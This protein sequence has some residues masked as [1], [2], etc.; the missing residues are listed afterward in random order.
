[1]IDG[2]RGAGWQASAT[3]D[4]LAG[5]DIEMFDLLKPSFTWRWMNAVYRTDIH[6]CC[7]F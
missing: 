5:I 3:I 4:T 2:I 1:M 7:F 6:T